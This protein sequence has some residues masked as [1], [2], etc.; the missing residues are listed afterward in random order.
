MQRDSSVA[1]VA[2]LTGVLLLSSTPVHASLGKAAPDKDEVV[3]LKDQVAALQG[4]IEVLEQ[5]LGAQSGPG[6]PVAASVGTSYSVNPAGSVGYSYDPFVMM[7]A[8]EQNMQAMMGQFA[9]GTGM[10][11]R[12]RNSLGA[13][14][15]DYDIK[16]SGQAYIITFDMPGMDKAKIN[17]EVKEGVLLVSGE[18]SSEAEAS[19]GSKV[20]RQQ[21]SFGY[22]SRRIPLPKDAMSDGVQARYDNGV[23][24]VTVNKKEAASKKDAAQKVE[25]K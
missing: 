21:R 13:F 12:A 10:M 16:E 25:V 22:F 1:M 17:V 20:Y 9:P 7:D 15:P 23:L 6:V 24:I 2:V 19:Q 5:K 11:P 4:K 8:M 14:S 3:A 18:R